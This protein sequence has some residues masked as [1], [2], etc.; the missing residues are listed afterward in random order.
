VSGSLP[1]IDLALRALA[2]PTV[3]TGSRRIDPADM[4]SLHP[5]ERDVIKNA[6]AK[7]QHEF[8]TGRALLRELIGAATLIPT[9]HRRA[10]QWPDGFCGSLAHDDRCAVAAVSKDPSVRA[11]GIDVE[12]TALL[13]DDMAALILRPEE[14]ALDAHLVF[15]LKEA[16]YKAWSSLGGRLLDHQ[17]VLV[18]VHGTR[19]DAR[20]VADGV[21]FE[22]GFAV[23]GDRTVA[24]VVVAADT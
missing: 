5:E 18:A 8:A 6:V 16:A 2:P 21:R 10:P 20:V 22:G 9:D 24:L 7:R 14:R 12:S 3:V 11:I 17:D 4:T 23:V 15:S 13:A 19:F 1:D